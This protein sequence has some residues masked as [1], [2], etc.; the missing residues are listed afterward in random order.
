MRTPEAGLKK[1]YLTK[2]IWVVIHMHPTKN[3]KFRLSTL[4]QYFGFK[5]SSNIYLSDELRSIYC[6]VNQFMPGFFFSSFS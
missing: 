4:K 2:L 6:V 5:F 1:I 3:E